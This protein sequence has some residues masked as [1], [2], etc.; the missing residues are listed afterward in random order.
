MNYVQIHEA[1][2]KKI[3]PFLSRLADDYILKLALLIA[4]DRSEFPHITIPALTEARPAVE[5]IARRFEDVLADEIGNTPFQRNVSKIMRAIK[6]SNGSPATLSYL[7]Q[8][9]RFSKRQMDQV[10]ETLLESH[11]VKEL[12]LQG[13]M[14]SI[15]ALVLNH[16]E[17]I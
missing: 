3:Q 16:E 17:S 12:R 9:T 4:V 5:W 7:Y 1:K 15:S 13:T 6:A 14:K 10:L 11:Q 8:R 2:D